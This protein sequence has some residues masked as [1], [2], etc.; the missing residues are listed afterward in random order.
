[1][2]RKL[3]EAWDEIPTLGTIKD[4]IY[5]NL[6]TTFLLLIIVMVAAFFP[7]FGA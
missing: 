3:W 2:P 1:M 4:W 5:L 6:D 7:G